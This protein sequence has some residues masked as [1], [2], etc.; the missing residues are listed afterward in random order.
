MTRIV[1]AFVLA[2][3]LATGAARA[4]VLSLVGDPDC[5]GVPGATACPPGTLYQTDLGGEFF[6]SYREPEDPPFTDVWDALGAVSFVH[7]YALPANAVSASLQLLFAGI[8]DIG[9][10][11]YDVRFNGQVIGSIPPI[12]G[13][14]AFELVRLFTFAVPAALL[15]GTDVVSWTASEGDGYIVDFSALR[16]VTRPE[17]MPVPEPAPALLLG[18]AAV[19]LLLRRRR[20]PGPG[21]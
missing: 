2:L 20:S 7:A 17:P 1:T 19:A 4:D 15:T 12:E 9:A 6:V 18:V 16:I 21:A 5:F 3:A 11:P 10:P 8:N 13:E 14:N